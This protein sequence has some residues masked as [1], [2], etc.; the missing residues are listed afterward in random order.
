MADEVGDRCGLIAFDGELRRRVPPARRNAKP[1]VRAL[2]DLEP[3][4]VE[5]DYELAFRSVGEAKRAFVLV[6]T[7]LLE[8]SAARPLV[9]AVPILARR[10]AV[11][12]ASVADTDLAATI[13]AE[14]ASPRD[15]YAASVALDVLA[16]RNRVV[17]QL[18]HAGA[19]VLE[20]SPECLAAACV[21]AYLRAK[22]FARL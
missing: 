20:A 1:V 6:L 8:E 3:S 22:A 19:D 15:V 11:V 14:P 7:D 18:R 16:A 12:V 10:H 5:S 9:E 13:A 21:A 2:F 4:P 17:R